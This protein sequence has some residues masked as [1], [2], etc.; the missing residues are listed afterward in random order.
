MF[1]NNC[2]F[3]YYSEFLEEYLKDNLH[4]LLLLAILL[5]A[6]LHGRIF[7]YA[8]LATPRPRYRSRP[9]TLLN[10]LYPRGRGSGSRVST[11]NELLLRRTDDH[12]NY[13]RQGNDH[14]SGEKKTKPHDK[15]DT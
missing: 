13:R 14:W 15:H 10:P 5:L 12:S 9:P 11:T 8:A 7:V 3:V 1:V 4:R 6:T 2:L